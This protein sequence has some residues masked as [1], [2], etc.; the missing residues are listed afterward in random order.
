MQRRP[1]GH[2]GLT[3][4]ALGF[5]AMQAGDLDAFPN[6]PA[7]ET[8]AQFQGDPRFRVVVGSTQG[9]TILSINESCCRFPP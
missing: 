7:A 9:E 5:G 2:T 3:V 8:I 6:F 4:P 1:F